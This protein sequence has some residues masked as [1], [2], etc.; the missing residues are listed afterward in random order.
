MRLLNKTVQSF[1]SANNL[2]TQLNKAINT[3]YIPT[4]DNVNEVVNNF[5][6]IQLGRSFNPYMSIR[7]DLTLTFNEGVMMISYT[8]TSG[9]SVLVEYKFDDSMQVKEIQINVWIPDGRAMSG[10]THYES[11]TREFYR[12]DFYDVD[13]T[14]KSV[15]LLLPLDLPSLNNDDWSINDNVP[16]WVHEEISNY[17]AVWD[18]R[19]LELLELGYVPVNNPIGFKLVFHNPTQYY[20][21][22]VVIEKLHEID[23]NY[24]LLEDVN[25]KLRNEGVSYLRLIEMIKSAVDKQSRKVEVIDY[26]Y[27]ENVYDDGHERVSNNLPEGFAGC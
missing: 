18:G 20:Q 22:I 19:Y 23:N 26:E 11:L 12:N 17:N 9:T 5:L 7:A 24:Y 6:K 21:Y 14:A 4:G 13:W 25:S 15:Q 2:I 10:R 1:E 3:S 27:D 16:N 8:S